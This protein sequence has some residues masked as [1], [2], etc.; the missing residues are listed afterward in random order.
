M[1]LVLITDDNIIVNANV[2]VSC[3]SIVGG[4]T[5]TTGGIMG[6]VLEVNLFEIG[7]NGNT[8]RV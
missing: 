8:P 4:H 5:T 1:I 6:R 2:P 7:E 3:F